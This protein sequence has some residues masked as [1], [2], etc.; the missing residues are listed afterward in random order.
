MRPLLLIDGTC[1]LCNGSVCFV[2][3]HER[4]P[5]LDFASLQSDV[6]WQRLEPFGL[7]PDDLQS[8]VLIDDD[9][10]HLRSEAVLRVA[11]TLRAPWSWARWLRWI[12]RAVR[13][14]LYAV[15]A[16]FRHRVFGSRP[17]CGAPRPDLQERFLDGQGA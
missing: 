14:G 13:D 2:V 12:P 6:A 4:E 16:R 11:E 5:E 10:A 7:D 8:L 3:D 1:N 15:V 9:G 17:A